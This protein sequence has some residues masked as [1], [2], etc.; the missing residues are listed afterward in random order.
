MNKTTLARL[1][2]EAMSE[3]RIALRTLYDALNQGQQKKVLRN[4]E[5]AELFERY[6]VLDE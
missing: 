5:V 4:E 3:T 6:N 2:E 1:T